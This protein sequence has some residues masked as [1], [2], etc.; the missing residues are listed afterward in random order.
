MRRYAPDVTRAMDQS[1]PTTRAVI[2]RSDL[3]SRE[4]GPMDLRTELA[5]CG[6]IVGDGAGLFLWVPVILLGLIQFLS[7]LVGQEERN[8][9]RGWEA[10]I[11]D[12]GY[13]LRAG[14]RR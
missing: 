3:A 14:A 7:W 9:H 12:D 8:Y 13:G 11:L 2:D 5:I 4:V 10:Q 1:I 6:R